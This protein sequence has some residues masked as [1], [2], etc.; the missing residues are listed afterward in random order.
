MPRARSAI[1]LILKRSH[2]GHGRFGARGNVRTAALDDASAVSAIR[3]KGALWVSTI[4]GPWS[5]E[6]GVTARSPDL[7]IKPYS[8]SANHQRKRRLQTSPHTLR[9]SLTQRARYIADIGGS[10]YARRRF[11]DSPPATASPVANNKGPGLVCQP[12][13]LT[14]AHPPFSFYPGQRQRP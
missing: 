10:R 1:V 2:S 6:C 13:Q 7:H 5:R 11:S 9:T 3:F 4:Y 8:D 14:F 12:T